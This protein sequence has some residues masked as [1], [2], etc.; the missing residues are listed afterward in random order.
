MRLAAIRFEARDPQ[1]VEQYCQTFATLLR[2]YV[3]NAEGV[4]LLGPAPAALAK[5]NNRYRWHL[6]LKAA[7]AKRLHEVIESG[8]DAMKQASIP[9]NGVRLTVD[10]DPVNLL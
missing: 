10:V 6:L 8:L 1:A 9:R 2:P 3:R 4:S 7:A 5:L